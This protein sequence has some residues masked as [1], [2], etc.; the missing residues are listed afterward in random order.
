MS[1]CFE[2]CSNPDCK[3][4]KATKFKRCS[5]CWS[6]AYCGAECQHAHWKKHKPSCK[7]L[8]N[9]VEP[10]PDTT[11]L[12]NVVEPASAAKPLPIVVEPAS[13]AKP[14]PNVVEPLDTASNSSSSSS[15]A[16]LIEQ[17][18]KNLFGNAGVSNAGMSGIL[19]AIRSKPPTCAESAEFASILSEMPELLSSNF[20]VP[21][22]VKEP[23]RIQARIADI[24]VNGFVKRTKPL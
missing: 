11:P 13:A 17:V 9:V 16:S 5:R 18:V 15:P 6:V 8:P 21:D 3:N 24:I 22:E 19:Y 10:A 12:P 1:T 7:L 23:Y 20:E 4:E 14:L 2:Q